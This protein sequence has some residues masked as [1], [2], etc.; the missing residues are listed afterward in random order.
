M[1]MIKLGDCLKMN[2]NGI[3][4]SRAHIPA[5]AQQSPYIEIS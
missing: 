2:K 4:L 1:S 3:A 5:K